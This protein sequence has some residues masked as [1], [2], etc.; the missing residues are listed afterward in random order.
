MS[1]ASKKRQQQA[2]ND[3]IIRLKR[4]RQTGSA[5]DIAI[6]DAPVTANT[7]QLQ[8]DAIICPEC[9]KID[10]EA[11]F[12]QTPPSKSQ[13]RWRWSRKRFSLAHVGP[14]TLCTICQFLYQILP[15]QSDGSQYHCELRIVRANK[16][17]GAQQ[18]RLV[19]SPAF[20]V[21]FSRPWDRS[22]HSVDDGIIMARSNAPNTLSGRQLQP[23]VDRAVALEWL[24]FC[25]GNHKV[26]NQPRQS[27]PEGFC[28]LDCSTRAILEWEQ[29][30]DPHSH[31]VALSYV[32]GTVQGATASGDPQPAG[33]LPN[34]LPRTIE[35]ALLL[36]H[37][38]GYRYLWV[39]RYCI[40]QDNAKS[41]H[42]Q[43]Q[44]MDV[45]YQNAVVTIIAAAGQD[46]H[47]GLPGVGTTPRNTQP[48][49]NIGSR[50][51]V[52]VKYVTPEVLNSKWNSR[53]WTYQEGILARR[54]L[55][56][57]DTQVYFQCNGMHCLESIQAPL[58]A[59]HTNNN[60]Q[61]RDP[62][63]MSRVF[64]HRTLGRT[65]KELDMRVSEYLRRTLTFQNDIHNAFRGILAA[66]EREFSAST[67][68]LA[69]LRIQRVTSISA[70]NG[71]VNGLLW[72]FSG[73]PTQTLEA[74]QRR[75]EFP[76]W[77]WLGWK[78]LG[79]K[80]LE[81]LYFFTQGH[82]LYLMP[83]NIS[84]EYADS[85]VLPWADNR[86]LILAQDSV[87]SSP[88]FIHIRG[89][90]LNIQVTANG[91]ISNKDGT[92]NHCD[93]LWCNVVEYTRQ[94]YPVLGPHDATL[95]FT[96][97]MLA[98]DELTPMRGGKVWLL[99]QPAASSF[100]ERVP[101][102]NFSTCWKGL[103]SVIQN[104]DQFTEREVRIG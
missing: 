47:H 18:T 38:L 62:V 16:V 14:Q 75:S 49:V 21:E 92:I 95:S 9:R 67:R 101:M 83:S 52:S 1:P 58:G 93:D 2:H 13:G 40:P 44:N 88:R 72:G 26:C 42:L 103:L 27:I 70:L 66:H 43:I 60:T 98:T 74:I 19:D 10:F 55:L 85:L 32:W 86:D 77:T 12:S 4:L 76:S 5:L 22:L 28:V 36:T 20:V 104:I 78:I 37:N 51:L 17:L 79:W 64:P 29:V 61:M 69:G 63:N 48:C 34:P 80:T 96:L 6:Q 31:Y 59:L 3:A 7:S 54:R 71:L 46:P 57:T 87:G 91:Y 45:I 50:T 97:L 89:P 41:K 35:D 25:E 23:E 73:F 102:F 33:I 100:F 30:V 90:T 65:E 53:G 15:K 11:I 24:R 94:A 82:Q 39:D 99:Y 8:S 56:F 81:P 84:M 68:I